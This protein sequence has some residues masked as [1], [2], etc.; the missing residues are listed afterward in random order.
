MENTSTP[1]PNNF[2][3]YQK[4]LCGIA[5]A[6]WVI[7]KLWL[8]DE[9]IIKDLGP[10]YPWFIMMWVIVMLVCAGFS[11]WQLVTYAKDYIPGAKKY[12]DK[13]DE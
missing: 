5:V 13:K 11:G 3:T 10:A 8:K 6:F 4:V 9:S 12:L 2:S 1:T 7:Y